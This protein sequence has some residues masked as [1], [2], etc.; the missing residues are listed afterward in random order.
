MKKLLIALL[1]IMVCSTLVLVQGQDYDPEGRIDLKVYTCSQHMELV[2]SEDGR[3]DVRT[4]WAHGYY[5]AR[6]GVD[7]NSAPV[8][9]Q[10]V[11]DF[12]QKLESIC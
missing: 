1:A 8:T 10:M 7:E 5:S 12:A 11:V 6:R 9:A 2:E 4:V 3:G